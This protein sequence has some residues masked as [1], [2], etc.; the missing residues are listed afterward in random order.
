M[1]PKLTSSVS[2]R[3]SPGSLRNS[4]RSARLRTNMLQLFEPLRIGFIGVGSVVTHFYMPALLELKS[5]VQAL[6][7]IEL[8]AAADVNE[9]HLARMR[10]DFG[11]PHVYRD[12]HQMLEKH[13][14]LH[15][16]II[17]T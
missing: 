1:S 13:P 9:A 8:V 16:V 17:C 12:Y 3:S 4:P 14:D 5:H 11:V 2:A 7:P 10:D 6:G 15:A